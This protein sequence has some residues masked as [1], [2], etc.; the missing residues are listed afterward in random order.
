MPDICY[1]KSFMQRIIEGE[2]KIN[3]S[4]Q[5]P[6]AISRLKPFAEKGRCIGCGLGK[7]DYFADFINGSGQQIT[8]TLK[9]NDKFRVWYNE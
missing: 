9:Q 8:V 3:R 2:N 4:K 6:P 1:E 5:Y 7:C